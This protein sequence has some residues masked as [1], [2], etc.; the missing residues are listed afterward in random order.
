MF[1]ATIDVLNRNTFVATVGD[2]I[3]AR[4]GFAAVDTAALHGTGAATANT[5]AVAAELGKLTAASYDV[6]GAQTGAAVYDNASDVVQFAFPNAGLN[7]KLTPTIK[8][9]SI[10]SGN[11]TKSYGSLEIKEPGP[12]RHQDLV[13]RPLIWGLMPNQPELQD[14]AA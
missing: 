9:A 8:I 13:V 6:F 4:L 11:S 12:A 1:V 3:A 7:S 14:R 5:A 2:S 10:T